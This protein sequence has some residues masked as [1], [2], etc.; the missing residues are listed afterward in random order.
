MEVLQ[1]WGVCAVA[2][3]VDVFVVGDVLL[4]LLLLLLLLVVGAFFPGLSFTPVAATR[5]WTNEE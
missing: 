3:V 4:L 2:H 1:Q 5:R